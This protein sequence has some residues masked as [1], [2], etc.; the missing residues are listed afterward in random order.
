MMYIYN[1][2][3]RAPEIQNR[4]HSMLM[5]SS[6]CLGCIGVSFIQLPFGGLSLTS[7]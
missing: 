7:Q 1:G 3:E 6:V 5:L 2:L 4:Y